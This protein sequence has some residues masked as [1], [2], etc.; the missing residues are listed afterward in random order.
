V[1]ERFAGK[2]A[3]VTGGTTGVG[4][5][6]VER[7][8][9]EGASVVFCGRRTDLGVGLVEALGVERA[10]FVRADVT[11]RGD[12]ERLH[13]QAAQRFDRLDVVVNNAGKV[14]VA[15]TLELQPKHWRRTLP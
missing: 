8:H 1:S 10:M 9:A 5:A 13:D 15:P 12:L 11:D 4:R 2:V 7:L 3:V 6:T 14:V